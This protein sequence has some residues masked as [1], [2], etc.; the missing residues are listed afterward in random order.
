MACGKNTHKRYFWAT[1]VVKERGKSGAEWSQSHGNRKEK[2]GDRTQNINERN[3]KWL[4]FRRERACF[5]A[6]QCCLVSLTKQ[7]RKGILWIWFCIASQRVYL[8]RNQDGINFLANLIWR[9][10]VFFFLLAL[11]CIC[12]YSLCP[13]WEYTRRICC[14]LCVFIYNYVYLTR[15]K[16]CQRIH[17]AQKKGCWI[18][19]VRDT[20]S[21]FSTNLLSVFVFICDC[22]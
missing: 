22:T 18:Q 20:D 5:P 17:A 10:C 6:N 3:G 14:S 13:C 12:V 2:R 16:V 9:L 8:F 7:K 15:Y 21:Q 4:K 1:D 11:Y 19:N